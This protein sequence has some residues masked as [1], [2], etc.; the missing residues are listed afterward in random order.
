MALFF[1]AFIYVNAFAPEMGAPY[2]ITDITSV[3]NK[4]VNTEYSKPPLALHFAVNKP[5]E[6]LADFATAL[7]VSL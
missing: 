6:Q 5:S 1:T 7:A 4:L 2:S 3:S